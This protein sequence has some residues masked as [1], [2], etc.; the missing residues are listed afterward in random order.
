MRAEGNFNLQKC[1]QTDGF[2]QSEL[3]GS[4]EE[5]TTALV[6]EDSIRFV[7]L[8]IGTRSETARKPECRAQAKPRKEEASRVGVNESV[9]R[10]EVFVGVSDC[11]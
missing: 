9:L 8:A 2:S 3:E 5:H 7:I 11:S 4:I 10:M 6:K 1:T